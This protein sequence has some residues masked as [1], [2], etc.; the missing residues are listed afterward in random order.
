MARLSTTTCSTWHWR[1]RGPLPPVRRRRQRGQPLAPTPEAPASVGG[2]P[3]CRSPRARG[4]ASRRAMGRR[5][6]SWTAE[7]TRTGT[8][9]SH[10]RPPPLHAQRTCRRKALLCLHLRRCGH[11]RACAVAGPRRE[12]TM[13]GQSIHRCSWNSSSDPIG[14]QVRRT[15]VPSAQ[16]TPGP[17]GSRWSPRASQCWAS[18]AMTLEDRRPGRVRHTPRR[19][20]DHEHHADPK[21]DA[22]YARRP[23]RGY[24]QYLPVV[25]QATG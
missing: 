17:H 6:C 13:A 21:G 10:R 20:Q 12:D 11:R 2:V 19:V 18:A 5:S 24:R 9:S 4:A 15:P 14:A 16:R 25:S 7:V 3:G 22:E 1:S 8:P 23:L